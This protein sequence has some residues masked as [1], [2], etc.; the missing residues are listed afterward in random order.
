MTNLIQTGRYKD[1]K[2]NFF[3]SLHDDA[4][5]VN[6]SGA[7]GNV[8]TVVLMQLFFWKRRLHICNYDIFV[9]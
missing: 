3:F 9:R 6:D 2:S 5:N 7:Y 8:S 1:F 4:C